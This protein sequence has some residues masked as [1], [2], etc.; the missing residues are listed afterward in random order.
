[1]GEDDEVGE[2][3][4]Q[5]CGQGGPIDAEEAQ[6]TAIETHWWLKIWNKV[7]QQWESTSSE[8]RDVILFTEQELLSVCLLLLVIYINIFKASILLKLFLGNGLPRYGFDLG[9]RS[10][11]AIGLSAAL[12][13]NFIIYRPAGNRDRLV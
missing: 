9:S 4:A 3:G 13:A 1:M 2:N 12:G 6:G 8:Y 7:D 10:R 5:L 11:A